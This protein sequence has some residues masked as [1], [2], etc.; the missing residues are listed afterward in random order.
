MFASSTE[1]TKTGFFPK[2]VSKRRHG[3]DTLLSVPDPS[4]QVRWKVTTVFPLRRM[5]SRYPTRSSQYTHIYILRYQWSRWDTSDTKFTHHHHH[6]HHHHQSHSFFNPEWVASS[7]G[8]AAL[9]LRTGSVFS[10]TLC[11]GLRVQLDT[12]YSA[13]F[14]AGHPVQD[15]VYIWTPCTGLRV[16]L[17]ILYRALC[18]AGHLYRQTYIKTQR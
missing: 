5:N 12:L 11:T 7:V 13:P 8:Y 14:S 2:Y 9:Q 4:I 16:Y 18:S 15:S 17:D 1:K 6:H 10:W 3:T